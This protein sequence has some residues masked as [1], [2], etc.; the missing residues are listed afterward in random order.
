MKNINI[1]GKKLPI[2]GIIM[3]VLVIG[4]ASAVMTYFEFQGTIKVTSP[5]GDEDPETYDGEVYAGDSIQEYAYVENDAN[6]PIFV[7]LYTTGQGNSVITY[8]DEDGIPL[9]DVDNDGMQELVI[10]PGGT[11]VGISAHVDPG[12]A[13]DI[14]TIVTELVEPTDVGFVSLISKDSNTW[15]PNPENGYGHVVYETVSSEFD[16]C[17]KATGLQDNTEYEL[18]YYADEPNRFEDW[19]GANPSKVIAT[20][21][22]G[23]YYGVD[24]NTLFLNDAKGIQHSLPAPCDANGDVSNHDYRGAPDFYDVATGAKLWL[25]PSDAFSGEDGDSQGTMTE[26][27]P[28]NYLFEYGL[29]NFEN[30]QTQPPK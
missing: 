4:T 20:I 11:E 25:V 21:T 19:G 2:L 1:F 7:E 22:T 28:D 5:F 8:Y 12:M 16:F 18:I 23:E 10:V 24:D 9:S 15:E 26:W 30:T 27:V 3:A 17:V 13:E 29:V 6:N 14:Y